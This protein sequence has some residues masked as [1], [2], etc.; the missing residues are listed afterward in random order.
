MIL[1]RTI[2]GKTYVSTQ[3]ILPVDN[4]AM[5][6][7]YSSQKQYE[8][9]IDSYGSTPDAF[10]DSKNA[11]PASND[12]IA[13]NLLAIS[14][15]NT[16]YT[17]GQYIGKVSDI[18]GKKLVIQFNADIS[19]EPEDVTITSGNTVDV[20]V[21][22]TGATVSGNTITINSIT[23]GTAYDDSPVTKVSTTING[24]KYEINFSKNLP[25]LE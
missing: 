12:P 1:S 19:Q 11:D 24:T 14:I 17:N 23:K 4:E 16:T 20:D 25:S 7:A 2:K 3:A 15:D 18:V 9:A 8:A 10:L 21:K 13:L 22:Q 5:I 6:Q